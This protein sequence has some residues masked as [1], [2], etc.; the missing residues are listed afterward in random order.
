MVSK[1]DERPW[2]VSTWDSVI[3]LRFYRDYSEYSGDSRMQVV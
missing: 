1:G 2:R 3:A